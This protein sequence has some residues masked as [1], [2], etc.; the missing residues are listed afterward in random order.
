MCFVWIWE[1]TAIISL[2]SIYWLV[3]I[4]EAEC[5]SCAV[6]NRSLYIILRSAHT[7]YLCVLCGSENK[8]RLFRCT[9]LTDWFLQ[10]R[11]I[12]FTARYGLYGLTFSVVGISPRGLVFNPR[13]VSVRFEVHKVALWQISLPVF[14]FS[15]SSIIPSKLHTHLHLLAASYQKDKR[16]KPGNL[17]KAMFLQKSGSVGKKFYCLSLQN[18][19]YSVHHVWKQTLP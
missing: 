18:I 8:Q 2:Y 13:Q 14:L 10:P 19:N 6:R 17:R 15:L 16:S 11:R 3:F 12:M 1:Q 7:V 4:T 5:V 9:A